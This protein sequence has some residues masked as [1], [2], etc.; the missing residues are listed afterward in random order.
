MDSGRFSLQYKAMRCFTETPNGYFVAHNATLTGDLRIAQGASFWFQT[1]VRGDVAPITI[2]SRVNVQDGSVIHCDTGVPNVIEDDVTIGHR[3]IVHGM[4]VGRGS[5][6]GMG[7]ILLSRT[8]IGRECLIAAGAVV[9]PDLEVPDRMV[10][11]G[12]PGKIVRPVKPE[13][14]QYMRWLT[15]NYTQLAQ[16]YASGELNE[17]SAVAPP[18]SSSQNLLGS[19]VPD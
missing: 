11:M 12:V 6:I 1:V 10:V 16:K 19:P 4:F 17:L 14:L 3:A 2:G 15:G 7:A 5:L 8:R 13:E 9:P 18:I